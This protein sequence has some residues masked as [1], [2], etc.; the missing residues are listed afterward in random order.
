MQM[1]DLAG[2]K[3]INMELTGKCKE[4]FEER[5]ESLD[6]PHYYF[7]VEFKDFP[8]SMQYGVYVDFFDSVNIE[9]EIHNRKDYLEGWRFFIRPCNIIIENDEF[10]TRQEAQTEAIKKANEIYNSAQGT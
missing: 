10:K 6:I 7:N 3:N 4:E 2:F 5:Y 1:F 8:F 9:I